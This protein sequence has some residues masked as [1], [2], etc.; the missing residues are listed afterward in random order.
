M[1]NS[2]T[3]N[4]EPDFE[5]Q[6]LEA[7]VALMEEEGIA[8]AEADLKQASEASPS[9]EKN[10]KRETLNNA[11]SLFKNERKSKAEHPDLTGNA[12]VDGCEYWMS[13]WRKT[14]KSG[15]FYSISL[16]PKDAP[17]AAQELI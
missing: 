10:S 7:A 2:T 4:Y 5:Q 13:A 11:G 16:R 8:K 3:Q 15:D 1:T 12:L 6:K 14:G 17:A 9:P